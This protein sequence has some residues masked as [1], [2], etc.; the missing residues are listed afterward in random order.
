MTLIAF[1]QFGQRSEGKGLDLT[2]VPRCYRCGDL[3]AC[4]KGILGLP[5]G[6]RECPYNVD[7]SDN[8]RVWCCVSCGLKESNRELAIDRGGN[9][10]FT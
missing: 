6:L 5:P 2:N 7:D 4:S 1:I 9:G 10:R 3:W 8:I